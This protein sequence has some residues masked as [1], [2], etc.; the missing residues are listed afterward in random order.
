MTV[1][2]LLKKKKLFYKISGRDFV[3]PCIN[4]EHDDSDPSMRIDS[5]LGIFHC[6]SCGYKGNL[7]YFYGEQLDKISMLKEQLKRKLEDI[8]AAS[9]GLAM[10]IDAEYLTDP[11]RVSAATLNEFEAFRST[12]SDFTNRVVFPI[13]DLKGKISCF[14]GRSE[15]AFDSVKY[16]ITPPGS[17]T[18]LFPLGKVVPEQG[19]VMLVEGLFD[20]LNL[21]DN[22][23]RNVLCAFG[24]RKVNKDKLQILSVMG[25]TGIDI[26]YDP[27]KAGQEAAVELKELAEEMFFNVRNI[28]LKNCD[29]G[30]LQPARA[31]KLREKLYE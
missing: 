29:P 1:E 6:L 21:Y 26:C 4:P 2:E 17:K 12:G 31:L 11:Y 3:V 30:D 9:I 25:V 16:K 18:P 22:G 5:I 14:V 8:R 24:T 13:K 7:F 27:D 23:Y 19:R 15:D 10:P 28:N 20:L